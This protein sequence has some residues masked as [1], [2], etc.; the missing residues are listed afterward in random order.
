MSL[1]RESMIK[2]EG[3]FHLYGNELNKG[4]LE[5]SKIEFTN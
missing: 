1:D 5:A 3:T 4:Y 2:V